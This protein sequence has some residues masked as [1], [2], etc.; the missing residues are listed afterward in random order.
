MVILFLE[1]DDTVTP[2]IHN[3]SLFN[4]VPEMMN[5][6]STSSPVKNPSSLIVF[7]RFLVAI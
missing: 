5:A 7:G 1:R 2:F 3:P 4:S 6:D